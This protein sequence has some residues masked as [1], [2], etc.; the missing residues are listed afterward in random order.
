[1]YFGF[2]LYNNKKYFVIVT[3]NIML[4]VIVIVTINT[5]PQNSATINLP[6]N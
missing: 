3:I 4:I 5:T 2:I 1:M 6:S